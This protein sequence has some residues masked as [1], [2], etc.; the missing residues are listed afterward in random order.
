MTRRMVAVDY[1]SHVVPLVKVNDEDDV[2]DEQGNPL[3]IDVLPEDVLLEIF[4]YYKLASSGPSWGWHRLIHV[5]RQWRSLVFA[6]RHRLDLRLLCTYGTPV[7]KTLDCWPPLPIVVRYGEDKPPLSPNAAEDEENIV[8]ALHHRER[9][10]QVDLVVGSSQFARLSPLLQKPFPSLESLALRPREK[11][12]ALVLP[13]AFLGR[14]GSG[15]GR[16]TTPRLRNLYLD[17]VAP[18]ASSSSSLPTA[19]ATTFLLPCSKDLV[20]LRLQRVPGD[21]YIPPDALLATLAATIRLEILCVQ[22]A[23]PRAPPSF[24]YPN[25]TT[26]T[27]TPWS[28]VPPPPS[29]P[30]F[31]A[32]TVRV[33]DVT[34][35]G[36]TRFEYRGSSEYLEDL[37]RG[38]RSAPSLARTYVSLFDQAT[39]FDVPHFA[40]F[41]ARTTMSTMSTTTTTTTSARLPVI[42]PSEAKLVLRKDGVFLSL[43]RPKNE[44]PRGM[45]DDD[46]EGGEEEGRRD[47]PSS[48]SSSGASASGARR[49]PN[50]P[51]MTEECLRLHVSCVALGRQV[52]TMSQ[53]CR[54]LSPLLPLSGMRKLEVV[55]SAT[56]VRAEDVADPSRWL[57]LFR[58]FGGVEDLRVSYGS[59]PDVARA[60][61]RVAREEEEKKNAVSAAAAV[62][63]FPALRE[64]RFDWFAARWEEAVGSF[65]AA[66][67]GSGHP[68][69]TFHRPKVATLS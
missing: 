69:I 23:A 16:T 48:S 3:T 28:P 25:P 46:D 1:V 34:L 45:D 61:Q 40:R 50:A 51:T 17:A 26:T 15:S 29:S 6:S 44:G 32:T 54:Q 53:L 68:P 12:L 64:L 21:A 20:C 11:N 38:I 49:N 2:A 41:V 67:Q 18:A 30:R 58:A 55:G 59:V 22:F 56:P 52:P 62:E 60:L 27:T 19:D 5:C 14:G 33:L 4:D 39:S 24:S 9:V 63:V 31:G 37:A 36:L 13:T 10:C 7:R 42:P 66:R 57:S 47:D 8:A 43:S 65:I 35:P